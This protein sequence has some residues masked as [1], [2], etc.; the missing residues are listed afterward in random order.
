VVEE[1]VESRKAEQHAVWYFGS[2]NHGELQAIRARGVPLSTPRLFLAR[3]GFDPKSVGDEH[4][5][6]CLF[7]DVL[8]SPV[9]F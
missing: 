6:C 9:E 5:V 2:A 7:R 3:P 8:I 4:L 1:H